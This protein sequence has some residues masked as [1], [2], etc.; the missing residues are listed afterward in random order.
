MVESNVSIVG[1]ALCH[2]GVFD[3]GVCRGQSVV[4]G[5]FWII[6][7][8]QQKANAAAAVALCL[9]N[10]DKP[11]CVQIKTY[12]EKRSLAQNRLFHKWCG[13]ISKQGQEYTPIQVMARAKH[14]WGVPL[15]IPEDEVFAELWRLIDEQCSHER[16]LEMLEEAVR[17]TSKL[18]PKLM[19]QFLDNMQRSSSTKYQLTDPSLYGLE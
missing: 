7:T 10:P 1:V 5:E 6:K 19:S 11:F 4:Q 3:R 12:E 16:K 2:G 18:S 9:V 17:V 14:T 8:D 15:L 13:E